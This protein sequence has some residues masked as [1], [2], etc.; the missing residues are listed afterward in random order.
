MSMLK[1]SYVHVFCCLSMCGVSMDVDRV[2]LLRTRCCVVL[3][4]QAPEG[5]GQKRKSCV[6]KADVLVTVGACV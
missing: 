3:L 6:R 4:R 5:D 1:L 2:R